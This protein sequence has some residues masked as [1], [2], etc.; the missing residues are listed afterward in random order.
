MSRFAMS[1]VFSSL[2]VLTCFVLLVFAGA[3]LLKICAYLFVLV[4]ISIFLC[5]DVYRYERELNTLL[6][7]LINHNF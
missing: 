1:V 2:V 6:A 4:G 7:R 3:S 5:V